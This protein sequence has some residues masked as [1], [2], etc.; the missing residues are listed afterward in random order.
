MTSDFQQLKTFNFSSSTPHLW[1]FKDSS[2]AARFKTFYVQTENELNN[3][4]KEF[5]ETEISRITEHAPYS[6][7]SQTNES[8]CLTIDQNATD[9]NKLKTLVDRL[10]PEHRIDDSKDLVG[11]KGYVV[12]F[13][14]NGTTVYAVKRSASTWKTSYPKKYIN[15]VFSN[16][17]LA[18]VEDKSFSIEKSFDFYVI[19]ST[20]FIA[21]KRGFESSMQHREAYVEAFTQLQAAPSF[22]GLFSDITPIIEYVGSNSIQLRRMGVIESKGVYNSQN[23][24]PNLIRVNA[25][26]NWGINFD[27]TSNTIIPCADTT[28]TILQILL[29]HRL[30]SEITDNTYDVPDAIE[31]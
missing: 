25:S 26:R 23:F 16:G 14:S 3:Q 22:N 21:N 29:D 2:S 7:I 13:I 6:Y 9:F 10:E 27:S 15:M 12:K 1:V 5:V 17:E 20:I 8:S 24:I 30:L 31:V 11:A 18:G 19:N 4:L 28:G